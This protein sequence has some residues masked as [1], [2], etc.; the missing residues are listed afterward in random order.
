MIREKMSLAGRF[1]SFAYFSYF[2]VY[3]F[4][5]FMDQKDTTKL[6]FL[7]KSNKKLINL[8]VR[9]GFILALKCTF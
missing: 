3:S 6:D 5:I 7:Y 4:H 1:Y 9:K 8:K 2:L